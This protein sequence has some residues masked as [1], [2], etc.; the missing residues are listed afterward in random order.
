MNSLKDLRRHSN[1][2]DYSISMLVSA[3]FS[4]YIRQVS[5]NE[6]KC[7]SSREEVPSL[8]MVAIQKALSASITQP[9]WRNKNIPHMLIRQLDNAQLS[10]WVCECCHST[11]HKDSHNGNSVVSLYCFSIV[12]GNVYIADLLGYTTVN[13]IVVLT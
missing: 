12:Y 1:P 13:N 5:M 11:V 8:K 10:H 6:D 7:I 2:T 4:N 3:R 9:Y